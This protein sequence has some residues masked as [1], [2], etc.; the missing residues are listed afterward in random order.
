MCEC[1]PEY[2]RIG[3]LEAEIE[4]LRARIEAC[5][6]E[7]EKLSRDG[8]KTMGAQNMWKMVAERVR[9]ILEQGVNNVK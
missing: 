2:E 6:V 9:H 8:T 1:E 7:F 3:E 5:A 4:R